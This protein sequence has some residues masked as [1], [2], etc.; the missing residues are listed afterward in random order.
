VHP[1]DVDSNELTET[2]SQIMEFGNS[3]IEELTDA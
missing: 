1:E 3:T 2:F